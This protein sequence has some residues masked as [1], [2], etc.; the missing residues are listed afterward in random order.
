MNLGIMQPYFMPYIGYFQLIN[1]TDLFIFYDNVNYIKGGWINRNVLSNGYKFTLPLKSVSSFKKIN[2]IDVDW[3]SKDI[4]KIYKTFKQQFSKSENYDLVMPLFE[5]IIETKPDTI[6]ETSILSIKLFCDYLGI[7]TKLK[8]SSECDYV[9]SDNKSDNIISLCKSENMISY[10][11][12][13][14]GKDLYDEK[15]FSEKGINLKFI[16]G[17]P[18]ASIF[19]L[20]MKNNKNDL[21]NKLDEYEIL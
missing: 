20:C 13:I 10:T 21:Y 1:S 17:S 14:G 7:K 11:N 4:T 6:S 12:P 18:S 5:K 15:Y 2:E 9:K 8:K 16:K 19:E 3:N